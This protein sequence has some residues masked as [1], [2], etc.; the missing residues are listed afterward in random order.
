MKARKILANFCIA[1]KEIYKTQPAKNK[2]MRKDIA[3]RRRL[4]FRVKIWHYGK[5]YVKGWYEK[6]SRLW[7]HKK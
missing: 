5:R 2:E 1:M 6:I 7:D 4:D 3:D